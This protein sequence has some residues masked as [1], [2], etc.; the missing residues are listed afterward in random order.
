M[1][2]II[3]ILT[4]SVFASCKMPIKES[5]PFPK[6]PFD[7]DSSGN[8]TPTYPEVMDF[9]NNACKAHKFASIHEFGE[10]DFGLPLHYVWLS[11]DQKERKESV[12]QRNKPI[13]LINNAIHPGEPDG[14]DASMQLAYQ[15]LN[16]SLQYLLDQVD[17]AII[18]M[19]NIGGGHNR[20]A[21]S[22]ANQNGPKEY[23]FRGNA[24]NLDLNRD[25]VKCDS[26]NA[27]AFANLIQK[28][29]PDF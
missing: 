2:K 7:L 14:V 25:F 15:L 21:S 5:N 19:Y 22:R 28:L 6:A 27:L 13:L 10:S 4:L 29:D 26:R 11:H 9:W 24:Q 16:D 12:E 17:I 23:G 3:F 20:S 8:T 18:P 1:N